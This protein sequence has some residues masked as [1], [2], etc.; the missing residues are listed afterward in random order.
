MKNNIN[1]LRVFWFNL[2]RQKYLPFLL[3]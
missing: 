3:T 1:L 2:Q